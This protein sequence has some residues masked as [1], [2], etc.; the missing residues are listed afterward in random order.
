MIPKGFRYIKNMKPSGDIINNFQ[1]IYFE[2]FK[3][4]IYQK[5]APERL[6]RLTNLLRVIMQSQSHSNIDQ[7]SE[8]V[9][10]NHY[11]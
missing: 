10:L 7:N 5:E 4:D 9:T 6:L 11:P 8:D 1:Q 3:E 2:K